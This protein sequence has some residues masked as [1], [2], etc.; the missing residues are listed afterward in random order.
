MFKAFHFGE[1]AKVEFQFQ[2][3]NILNHVNLATPNR[4]VDCANGGGSITAL[5]PGAQMRRLQFGLKLNF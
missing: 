2:A 4:C 3:Y 1:K 5:T